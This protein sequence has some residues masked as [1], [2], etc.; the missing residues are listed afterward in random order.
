MKT[1]SFFFLIAL[2]S[3]PAVSGG[4]EYS[5]D[6]SEVEK[7]ILDFGGYL[8][9]RPRLLGLDFD[10]ALYRLSSDSLGD[11]DPAL[12]NE[13]LALLD[14][15]FEK[16]P[17]TV[18]ARINVQMG[19]S[20]SEWEGS[21]SFYE[22]FAA[23]QPSPAFRID[24]GKKR[25]KWGKGYAW[26]PAAFLNMPK[27]PN[28]P[29]LALEGYTVAAAEITRSFSGP[30]K[31]LSLMPVL[32]PIT[33]RVNASLGRGDTLN[34]GGKLYFLLYDTD[35]DLIALSGP[36]I[37]ES[38]GVDF[39]RNLVPNLEIHGEWAY[40]SGAERSLY[41]DDGTVA[42]ESFDF[43][44][45]LLGFRWLTASETTFFL[46]ILH[47]GSGFRRK[48]MR[49]YYDLI[50]EAGPD[51]SVSLARLAAVPGDRYRT[52]TPMRDY[53]YLRI[54]QK[55]PFGI[56]YFYP[57]LMSIVNLADGSFSL[58]P[59]LLYQPGS[60][61]ELRARA[62]FLI[63]SRGSEFGEKSADWRLELRLRWYF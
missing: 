61:L 57:A 62:S 45:W 40:R 50:R 34:G 10:A 55:E 56:L 35:I 9:A 30:L 28:D 43:T 12:E 42:A 3:A 19:Y 31:T 22:I 7:K 11:G 4:Q 1:A 6:L 2:L 63:G 20:V 59:E 54:H 13:F 39:S 29:D 27:N 38:L 52:F 47:D 24:L 14:A 5:F 36:G 53:F 18:L 48:D 17:F 51:D 37:P 49:I 23:Y 58:T 33:G 60:D 26:N 15:R 44:S 25:L 32:V 41:L 8:E 21:T 46:E 16:G